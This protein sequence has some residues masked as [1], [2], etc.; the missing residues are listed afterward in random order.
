MTS[1]R[2]DRSV[3]RPSGNWRL[4]HLMFLIV[5]VAITMWLFILVGS[6][7]ILTGFVGLVAAVIG[8]RWILRGVRTTRQD[9]LLWVMAIAAEQKMPLAPAVAA[10]ADQYR[11]RSY[12]KIAALSDQLNAGAMV[13]EA[14]EGTRKLVSLHRGS[15]VMDRPGDRQAAQGSPHGGNLSG[16]PFTRL[17]EHRRKAHVHPHPSVDDADD[18]LFYDVFHR[19]QV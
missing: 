7:L 4:S 9:S 14:F 6:V 2:L 11:G 16:K 17:D 8:G 10:F 12:R 18:H 15:P 3:M 1:V 19:S 5:G 13:P